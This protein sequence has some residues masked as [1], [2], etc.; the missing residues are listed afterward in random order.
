MKT[1]IAVAL[2]VFF[3]WA[4]GSAGFGSP[5]DTIRLRL[6]IPSGLKTEVTGSG[7]LKL[8]VEN[9]LKAYDQPETSLPD[10]H[11]SSWK[12]KYDDTYALVEA[13]RPRRIVRH[14]ES[15]TRTGKSPQTGKMETEDGSTKDSTVTLTL[16]SDGG[17]TLNEDAEPQIADDFKL[18]RA[19]TFV[20]DQELSTDADWPI[21]EALLK[22][23]L[24]LVQSGSGTLRLAGVECPSPAR[25][26]QGPYHRQGRIPRDLQH[27]DHRKGKGEMK[28]SLVNGLSFCL[29]AAALASSSS[30]A[31]RDDADLIVQPALKR[32][33]VI[34]QPYLNLPVKTGARLR[35]MSLT[36]DGE[37]ILDFN[38]ELAKDEPDFW[39]FIDVSKLMGK[40]VLLQIDQPDKSDP[41]VLD[42]IS[43]DNKIKGADDLY[44]ERY[45]PRFHFTS[46]RG[47]NNDPNGLIYHDGEYHLFYQHNPYGWSWGNM[48]WGHAVS[49]DLVH[50]RELGEAIRPDRLGTIF[51]GSAVV[52]G[53]NSGGFQAGDKKAI[54]CF[55]TSAG[56]QVEPKAPF[57]QS[58]AFSTD[59]GRTFTKLP[60]NPVVGH[61]ADANRDPK[62]VR[63][64]P[65]KTWI[66]AL[67][68][69]KSDYTLLSSPDLKTWTRLSD[70]QMPG[71]SECP[72][73]FE[74]P[75]DGNPAK[76]KW[77]FWAAD[78]S[79]RIGSFDGKA[80]TPESG[81]LKTYAGGTAYAAQTFSGIPGSDGRRIQ[82]PWLRCDM[83]G[84]PFNQQMGFPV[85]LTL[86]TTKEGVRLHSRPIGE[87]AGLYGREWSRP[88]LRVDPG[89]KRLDGIEGEAFDIEAEIEIGGA[90]EVGMTVRGIPVVYDARKRLLTCGSFSASLEP[91]RGRIRLRILVDRAS[92]EIFAN[93]GSLSM[94]IG[95]LVPEKERSLELS[96]Q[97]GTAV[98]EVLTIH[99]VR[100]IWDGTSFLQGQLSGLQHIGLPVS[101]LERSVGFYQR[102]GF[103]KVMGRRFDDGSGLIQ[104]AMMERE[105]VV[106]ELYQLPP[107]QIAA[108]IRAR[109][110]GHLDHVAFNVKDIDKAF[111]EAR[112]AGFMPLQKEPVKLDFWDKG[113]RYFS[114]RGP[115][116]EKLE[117][118]QIL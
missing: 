97:G 95:L 34:A 30:Y 4:A 79:Y 117:F 106:M 107:D 13:G 111:Q 7:L 90:E 88:S 6:L 104:V 108:D 40:S 91:E 21:P 53:T 114:I 84:M 44:K 69:T 23:C 59:N 75:V 58:L 15:D 19:G 76:T 12:K 78:G 61:I 105:G 67:Y 93:D 24:P 17:V 16:L 33:I 18:A 45:R 63:H 49:A 60:G 42:R 35:R 54:V 50:W 46:R 92:I 10:Q 57:T 38:I 72:D 14:T 39:A 52:D 9:R 82:I 86:R 116:G 68:L 115:D 56:D 64:A 96:A 112:D 25:S 55:Y 80:F 113:C 26:G 31:K 65:T 83:T 22:A 41:A 110:D 109:K 43:Q 2:M 74:L 36:A 100:S 8:S 11:T 28:R 1:K 70:V 89:R 98:V 103:R 87:I 81:M 66:M 5:P 77:I 3:G 48:H 118:N 99:E 20:A 73:L 29:L 27:P 47:W 51:S 101:D 94:P 85:D 32:T 102:L 37:K 62:V 71:A